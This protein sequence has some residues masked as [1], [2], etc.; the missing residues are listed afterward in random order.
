MRVFL[1]PCEDHAAAWTFQHESLV[2]LAFIADPVRH[3]VV[4]SPAEADII[5]ISDV[6]E[7]SRFASLRAHPLVTRYPEQTFVYCDSD[8]PIAFVH[9]VYVSVPR[10]AVS[11][12][13][14]EGAMYVTEVSEWTNPFVAAG[15]YADRDLLFSFI[16]R[17][18]APVR[19]HLLSHDFGRSDVIV[20]DTS[21]AYAHWDHRTPDRTAFQREYVEMSRRS[22]F[23]VCPRGAGTSTIRLFEVM[24]MGIAPIILSDQWMRPPGPR[25]DDFAIFVKEGDVEALD[26]IA[27]AHADR[28]EEMGRLAAANWRQWFRPENQFNYIVDRI[29]SIQRRQRVPERLVHRS[30]A[31]AVAAR[32]GRSLVRRVSKRVG[33]VRAA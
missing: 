4:D 33:R 11:L 25:W 28:A 27:L 16:G 13:R 26:R 19:A 22:R 18:S 30:W 17:N 2:K 10:A 8:H 23:V 1:A 24:Q 31:P 9:G 15:G 14:V 3:D 29:M 32:R 6:R 7:E 21:L 5:I 12:G 20:R